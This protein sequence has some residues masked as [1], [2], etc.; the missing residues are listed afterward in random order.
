MAKTKKEEKVIGS[1]PAEPISVK[2][3]YIKLPDY[4]TVYV[5]GGTGGI[6]ANG[7]INLN[8]YTQRNTIPQT[9]S[10][11]VKNGEI[12]EKTLETKEG[13]VREVAFGMIFDLNS[14][15]AIRDWLTN[16][17]DQLDNFQKTA[18]QTEK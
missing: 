9:G 1:N 13:F 2:I 15:I 6:T 5:N 7:G 4:K 16:Q 8:V 11:E 18:T 17:I 3:H 14:A 10:L 12:T